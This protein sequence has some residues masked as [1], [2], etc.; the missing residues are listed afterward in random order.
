MKKISVLRLLLSLGLFGL[1][2]DEGDGA[3]SGEGTTG[4][5]GT[6]GT[7]EGNPEP[8]FG[9]EGYKYASKYVSVEDLEKG[10][11]EQ[12]SHFNTK[13]TE[14]NEKFG[15][16]KGAPEGDYEPIKDADGNE[17]EGF[18]P[19]IM[20]ELQAWGKENGLSQHKYEDVITRLKTKLDQSNQAFI[21]EELKKL[22]KDADIRIK[23]INDAWVAQFG[24]ESKEM[25]NG[26]I[27]TAADAEFYESIIEKLGGQQVNPDGTKSTLGTE[28]ITHDALNA[29]MFAKTDSGQRKTLVDPEYAA[30]V[31][32]MIKQYNK[33]KR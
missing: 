26:K 6:T 3:G 15:A 22:G 2:A 14:A 9:E 28:R 12:Q 10:Y 33:Q 29:A 24:E 30:K 4:T 19:D 18:S 1:F 7:G 16:F 21:Q 23:N 13:L 17:I 5:T 20:S 25:M 11:V 31:E 32:E 8:K 27:V